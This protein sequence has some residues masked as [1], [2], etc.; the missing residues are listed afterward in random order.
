MS[1]GLSDKIRAM[2]Q[3]NYVH[4]AITSGLDHFS[5]RVRDVITALQSEGYPTSYT[6]QICSALQTRKFLSDNG[7]EI[8]EVEGPAKKVSPTVVIKYRIKP[9]T[10]ASETPRHRSPQ[11]DP[12]VRAFR[13]TEKIRGI[14]KDELAAYG[15]GEAFLRWIR[16]DDEDAA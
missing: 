13:L 10:R 9:P 2:A 12:S 11:E 5:I 15:G 6:P 7:L 4:P 3:T 1:V 14:L 16:S 8:E